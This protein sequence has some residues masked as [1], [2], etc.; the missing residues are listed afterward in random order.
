MSTQICIRSCLGKAITDLNNIIHCFEC[1]KKSIEHSI[2]ILAELEDKLSALSPTGPLSDDDKDTYY[3]AVKDL[4]YK[5]NKILS[6]KT[7]HNHYCIPREK[8]NLV[9]ESCG[10]DYVVEIY[11]VLAM[12]FLQET[13]CEHEFLYFEKSPDTCPY[14]QNTKVTFDFL[15]ENS[16]LYPVWYYI[17][18]NKMSPNYTLIGDLI[19]SNITYC[20]LLDYRLCLKDDICLQSRKSVEANGKYRF[21]FMK[22][23]CDL[24]LPNPQNPTEDI[25]QKKQGIIDGFYTFTDAI[26]TYNTNQ[27][28]LIGTQNTSTVLNKLREKIHAHICDIYKFKQQVCCAC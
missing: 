24:V 28:G 25:S 12:H 8:Q 5:I 6:K 23:D 1:I 21:E 16:V 26:D 10:K 22:E 9:F 19:S 14:E 7:L 15:D 11:P 20:E 3:C 13:N 18:D 27:N 4:R 2:S 17:F